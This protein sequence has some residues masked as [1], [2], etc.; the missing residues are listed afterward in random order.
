MIWRCFKKVVILWI[1]RH[2]SVR[3]RV[4]AG[5]L[6]LSLVSVRYSACVKI[7]I[8]LSKNM[9]RK[10]FAPARSVCRLFSVFAFVFV[11]S[12]LSAFAIDLPTCKVKGKEYYYYK[13]EKGETIYSITHRLG[14]TH[15][16]IVKYNPSVVDG[17]KAG[18]TLYFPVDEFGDGYG[19]VAGTVNHLVRKGDTLFGL[20][21]KY[22]VSPEAILALNPG[23]DKGIKIGETLRIPIVGDDAAHANIGTSTEIKSDTNEV[24]EVVFDNPA[25]IK[26]VNPELNV[27][28]G[29]EYNPD[30]RELSVVV[31][32][33]FMLGTENAPRAAVYATDFYRGMLVGIDSLR[34]EYGNPR[35][36]ITAIDSDDPGQPFNA[37]TSKAETFRTADIIVTS[38]NIDRLEQLGAFGRENHVYVFNPFQA[39]DTTC[40]TNPY[41][42]Q[43]N[44]L[45]PEM[46]DKS[47]GYFVDHLDGAVPVFLDNEKGAKD[48]QGF[49][50]ALRTRLAE[51]GID[52]KTLNYNGT[53]TSSAMLDKLPIDEGTVD[54]VFVPMS[55]SLGE[56]SK[57]ATALVRYNNEVE[58]G[59]TPGRV[60][61]FGYPEYTRFSGDPLE[62]IHSIETTFYSRF[63]NDADATETK[64]IGDSFIHW[65]GTGLPDGVPNQALYGFDVARWLLSL[66]SQ[67]NVER[68][69]IAE[70][71]TDNGAQMNYQ[72]LDVPGGG[73]VNMSMYIVT[74]TPGPV[75]T[76]TVL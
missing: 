60:R 15:S 29:T 71:V 11:L 38:D 64:A 42:I 35:I 3:H 66:A 1:K 8:Q 62:K 34:S 30:S 59:E 52:Y 32:L 6:A 2:E 58:S 49:V 14:V 76:I 75:K 43:G 27:E 24:P 7:T 37:L 19:T 65:F 39:R 45:Q 4:I 26:P 54:Y 69:D 67:G 46:F 72:F 74:L 53:M 13:V 10:S 33:P 9:F 17:V 31:C 40:L 44:I 41:M 48:K 18:Q 23:A 22:G 61:L 56:F 70:S 68:S 16:E 57:F 28:P 55:G 73:F 25:E 50:D 21:G 20:S 36:R 63:Y 47:I 51:K 12:T 5:S